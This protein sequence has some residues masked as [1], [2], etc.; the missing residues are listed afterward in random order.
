VPQTRRTIYLVIGS[1][2]CLGSVLI[3]Y[4]AAH[5]WFP[6][7]MNPSDALSQRPNLALIGLLGVVA[8]VG[9]VGLLIKAL[10]PDTANQRFA[11]IV[12][13]A[14]LCVTAALAVIYTGQGWIRSI[15]R[16]DDPKYLLAWAV[17]GVVSLVVLF[18]GVRAIYEARRE[19]RVTRAPSTSGAR[20]TSHSVS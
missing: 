7:V 10:L 16:N 8:L 2:L 1:S 4:A 17:L 12:L 3:F 20:H 5:Q 19:T 14:T 6:L 18:T 11:D 9:G 15:G 13:G